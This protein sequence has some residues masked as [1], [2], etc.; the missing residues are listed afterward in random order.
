MQARVLY[1]ADAYNLYSEIWL[2]ELKER[3]QI[4]LK[5]VIFRN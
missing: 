1:K 3:L 5:A 4:F 2:E